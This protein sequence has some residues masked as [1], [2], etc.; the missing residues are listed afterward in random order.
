[1]KVVNMCRKYENRCS[2][3]I[4]WWGGRTSG[5]AHS[6]LVGGVVGLP[7]MLTRDWLVGW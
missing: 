7:V 1:M 5:D 2:L 4:G 6:R 3:A